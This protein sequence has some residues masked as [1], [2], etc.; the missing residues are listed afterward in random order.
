MQDSVETRIAR[1]GRAKRVLFGLAALA[2]LLA[3]IAA[4]GEPRALSAS[5]IGLE[6]ADGTVRAE[7]ALREGNPGLFIEDASGA[8]RVA[9]FHDDDASGLYMRDESGVTRIGIA[10]FAHGGG[11]VALHGPESKGAAVLYFEHA[12]SLRFFDAGDAVLG[13]LPPAVPVPSE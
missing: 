9:L 13:Q 11:G 2:V 3:L 5:S 7:L 6:D 10:Q 12:G 4:G 8:D 1:L